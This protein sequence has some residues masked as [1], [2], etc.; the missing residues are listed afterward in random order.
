MKSVSAPKP[1]DTH[2]MS[3]QLHKMG[4][5]N[6]SWKERWFVLS[7]KKLFYYKNQKSTNMIHFISLES[8]YVRVRNIV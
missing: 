7:D 1:T 8:A 6:R 2:E 4:V 5:V 3:G